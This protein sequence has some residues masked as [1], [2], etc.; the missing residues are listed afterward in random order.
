MFVI[1]STFMS[2]CEFQSFNRA[3]ESYVSNEM[4][5]SK[6]SVLNIFVLTMHISSFTRF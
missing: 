2:S 5:L 1:N 3:S 4:L 6:K